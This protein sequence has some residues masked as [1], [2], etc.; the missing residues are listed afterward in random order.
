MMP[1]ELDAERRLAAQ[2]ARA[3]MRVADLQ[4]QLNA[5]ELARR[6]AAPDCGRGNH[7]I[8]VIVGCGPC[9]FT[10]YRCRRCAEE[11]WL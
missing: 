8:E 4:R 10:I 11:E 3:R 7:D 1:G 6:Q 5:L 2:L 9:A